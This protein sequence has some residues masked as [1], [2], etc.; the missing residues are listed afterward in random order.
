MRLHARQFQATWPWAPDAL[1]VRIRAVTFT[2]FCTGLLGLPWLLPGLLLLLS[3][4]LCYLAGRAYRAG[5]P[6]AFVRLR[7]AGPAAPAGILFPLTPRAA[8]PLFFAVG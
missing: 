1:A 8:P 5:H 3:A 7:R 2:L 6:A 4:A